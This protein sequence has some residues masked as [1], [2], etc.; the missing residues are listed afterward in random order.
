MILVKN[1]ELAE[2]L[3]LIT[4]SR[5]CCHLFIMHDNNLIADQ[6]LPGYIDV[7]GRVIFTDKKDLL[8]R[9]KKI[10]RELRPLLIESVN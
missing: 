7:K 4:G 6:C 3:A 5:E 8:L 10:D 2:K 1:K 9:V